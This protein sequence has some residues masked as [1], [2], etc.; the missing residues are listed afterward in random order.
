MSMN[1][2][3]VISEAQDISHIK[4][5]EFSALKMSKINREFQLKWGLQYC[6]YIQTQVCLGNI[7]AKI[8]L[9]VNFNLC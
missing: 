6:N 8:L 1:V 3:A 4:I 5:S 9:N 2:R 7:L